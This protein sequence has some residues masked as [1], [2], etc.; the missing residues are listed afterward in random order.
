M[1]RKLRNFSDFK[2][3][4]KVKVFPKETYMVQNFICKT[5]T[6]LYSIAKGIYK[7]YQ[8]ERE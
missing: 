8:L 6:I 5:S 2:G 4:K 1:N 7:I 3:D